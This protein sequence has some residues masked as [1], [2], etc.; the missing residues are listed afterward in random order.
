MKGKPMQE[1]GEKE[2]HFGFERDE[3]GKRP[4]TK[5]NPHGMSIGQLEGFGEN[6]IEI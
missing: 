4:M 6:P 5:W 3:K 2:G 1:R